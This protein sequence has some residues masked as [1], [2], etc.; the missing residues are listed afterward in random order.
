M[1]VLFLNALF[2]W[3]KRVY[4]GIEGEVGEGGEITWH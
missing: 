3:R 2:K 4:H 1:N